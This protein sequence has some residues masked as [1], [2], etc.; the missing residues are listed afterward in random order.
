MQNETM[1]IDAEAARQH[2]LALANRTTLTIAMIVWIGMIVSY[3]VTGT[4][5]R[6]LAGVV[7]MIPLIWHGT[8]LYIKRSRLTAAA[9]IGANV[10]PFRPDRQHTTPGQSKSSGGTP[11]DGS[12]SSISLLLP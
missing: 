2:A 1:S 7:P 8:Y 6:L 9:C 11:P 10:P 3:F 4:G 5:W 12:G